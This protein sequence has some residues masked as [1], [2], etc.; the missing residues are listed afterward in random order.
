MTTTNDLMANY[1]LKRAESEDCL[2]DLFAECANRG[3]IMQEQAAEIAALK[4]ELAEL[5]APRD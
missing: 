1:F 2:R 4:R 5:K 3:K